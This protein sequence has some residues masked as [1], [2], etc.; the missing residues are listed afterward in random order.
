MISPRI[1]FCCSFQTGIIK[2][3][4]NPLA[5][6]KYY[7]ALHVS[8]NFIFHSN[9]LLHVI[10]LI[11][12]RFSSCVRNQSEPSVM[13]R[14]VRSLYSYGSVDTR[15]TPKATNAIT[16]HCISVAILP[17]FG[18]IELLLWSFSSSSLC[19]FC[20]FVLCLL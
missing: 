15:K 8:F 1:S 12:Y 3:L 16:E 11:N 10:F 14:N 17:A 6:C 18:C 4:L 7:D 20:L 9:F 13:Q 5:Y 2:R 19:S